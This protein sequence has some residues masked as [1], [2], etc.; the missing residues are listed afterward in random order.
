MEVTKDEVT[1]SLRK[2]Q[3]GSRVSV[4]RVFR[5]SFFATSPS[6]LARV[7]RRD[8]VRRGDRR[9]GRLRGFEVASIEP[10]DD[11]DAVIDFEITANRPD[12]LSVL[13]LA[14]EVATAY[15]LP[16]ALPSSA[17]RRDPAAAE[18]VDPVSD[19]L[20]VAID[21]DELCPRCRRWRL[22]QACR[23]AGTLSGTGSPRGS[24]AAGVR[25]PNPIVD[26][27]NYVNLEIG[28]PMHA[29]DHVRLLARKSARAGPRK[30]RRHH[31][32]RRHRAQA[33]PRDARDRR[34]RSRAGGGGRDGAAAS[35]VSSA[36]TTAVFES[37]LFLSLH[38]C[39]ARA[40]DSASRP[41]RPRGS[42]AAPTSA[43]RRW[44][45]NVPSP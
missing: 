4:F 10:L 21:D 2:D 44:R 25:P 6:W 3:K 13:G 20:T 37:A 43:R 28:Q 45:F 19:R 1:K 5:G 22:S 41:K 16:I 32:A 8:G 11:G 27:T 31:D 33:R 35:E 12:C 17:A 7:C 15:D 34:P 18:A 42:S 23:S 26:I 40:S 36:T 29:F 39:A 38:P 9:A 30:G 14:R 24:L